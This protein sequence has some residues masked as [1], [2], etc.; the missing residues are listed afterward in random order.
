MR[1]L[2]MFLCGFVLGM[3]LMF[4]GMK[5]ELS[6]ARH[7]QSD[8]YSAWIQDRQDWRDGKPFTVH[9]GRHGQKW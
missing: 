2:I 8:T 3:I 1:N 5:R 7:A 9:T 4:T 6:K